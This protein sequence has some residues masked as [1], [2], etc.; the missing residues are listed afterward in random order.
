MTE[1]FNLS[2]R[3]K[4]RTDRIRNLPVQFYKKESVTMEEHCDY[5]ESEIRDTKNDIQE[6]IRRLKEEIDNLYTCEKDIVK[7]RIDM[8]AGDELK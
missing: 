6:F 3:I 7:G 5:M 8:L 4:K 2:E 1:E